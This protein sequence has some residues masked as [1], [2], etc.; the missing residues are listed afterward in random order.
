MPKRSKFGFV[1]SNFTSNRG[2][3]ASL[4]MRPILK[5]FGLGPAEFEQPVEL[6]L[7][8]M[9]NRSS[10]VH[11]SILFTIHALWDFDHATNAIA[12]LGYASRCMMGYPD[13]HNH[14]VVIAIQGVL[15]RFIQRNVLPASIGTNAEGLWL[16][17]ATEDYSTATWYGEFSFIIPF[18]VS[19][20]PEKR[21]S[22]V[23]ADQSS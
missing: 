19:S 1:M 11:T 9:V 18:V 13:A 6:L 10:P 14:W 20:L 3:S 15:D 21:G 8:Q 16:I 17:G 7:R 12:H 22:E 4:L 23:A 5:G 2:G